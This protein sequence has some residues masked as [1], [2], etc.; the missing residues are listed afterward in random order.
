MFLG[1]A[2]RRFPTLKMG[3][4][5]GGV[6]WACALYSDLIGHWKKRNLEALEEVNPANLN[7][8][9]LAKLM[10]QYGG[11]WIEGKI[12]NIESTLQ[13][14]HTVA[15]GGLRELDDYAAC[16]IKKGE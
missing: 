12:D 13:A 7:R 4:L 6:G 10:R 15:T 8:P 16:K 5:E 1:G 11:R 14:E 9:L 3:F 2:T